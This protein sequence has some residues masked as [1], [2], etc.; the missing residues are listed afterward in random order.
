MKKLYL[1]KT[2]NWHNQILIFTNKKSAKKW[3]RKSTSL[4]DEEIEKDIR[5]VHKNCRGCFDI[6]P[7]D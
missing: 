6:F 3:M 7:E 2:N 1:V 4:T 5:I